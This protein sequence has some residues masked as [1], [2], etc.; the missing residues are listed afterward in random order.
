[1]KKITSFITFFL[2]LI[3]PLI[4]QNQ[5]EIGKPIITTFNCIDYGINLQVW[6]FV[7]DSRGIIYI[8]SAPGVFEFDGST[9][10]SIPTINNTHARS[11]A[12]DKNDRVYVGAS[13]DVGYLKPDKLGSL[14]FI[15]LL[16]EINKKYRTFSYV[17]TTHVINGNIY[18]QSFESIFR[19]TPVKK[20]SG[21]ETWKVKTWRP[22]VRFNYSFWLDNAYFVQQ[23]G[24]GLMKMVN[25]SLV[26]LPGGEQFANDRLQVMLPYNKDGKNLI[27]VGTFNKGLFLFDGKSFQP[28]ECEA[29]SFFIL[30]TLYKGK[31]LDDGSYVFVTLSG[32]MIIMD[33]DGNIKL[34]LNKRNGLSSNSVTGLF[35]DKGIIWISPEGSVSIVE[36]PSPLTIFDQSAGQTSSI[37]STVRYKGIFYISAT[38]GVF[39]LDKKTSTIK[40][41]TGFLTGNSQS[42]Q[43]KIVKDQLLTTHGTGFYRIIGTNASVIKPAAGLSFVPNF[44]H[45]SGLDSNRIFVGLI[46][47][48]STFYLD[49]KNEWVFEGKIDSVNDYIGSIIETSPGLLWASTDNNGILRLDFRNRPLHSPLIKRFSVEQGLPP[50]GSNAYKTSRNDYF[51]FWDGVYTYDSKKEKF[52]KNQVFSNAAN[53]DYSS[54]VMQEDKIGNIW[55][56]ANNKVTFYKLQKDGS[57]RPENTFTSRLARDAIG[58]IYPEDNG[59]VWFG[60][61]ST[62]YRLDLNNIKNY[63]EEFSTLVRK[64]T[65]G[66]DSVIFGGKA[67]IGTKVIP[68]VNF[69]TNSIAFDYSA[70]S[71]IDPA[72]TEYQS[73]LEG[74][75]EKW[76]LWKKDNNRNYTNLPTGDYTFKVRARNLYHTESKEAS[77][78]FDILTPWYRTWTAYLGYFLVLAFAVFSIDKYQ[79][80]RVTLKERQKA[81]MRETELRAQTAEAKSKALQAENERKKNIELLSEIGKEI[82][83][84]LDLDTI[85]YRLY[86]HVNQLADATIFGV[87]IYHPEKNEIEYRLA[88]EEGK[89]YP[90]YSRNTKDENQFPVWCILNRKPIFIND[91]TIE[92]KNYIKYYKELESV[93]EDGTVSKE[94]RSLI[95]LPLLSKERVLGVITIQSFKKEAY[96]NYH[97]NILQNLASYTAIAIDNADAYRQLNKTIEKLDTAIEDLKSTQE[98]LIVQQKLASLGQLTAGIAHEIKNPLNFVNN[99]AQLSNELVEELRDEFE[100]KKNGLDGEFVEVIQDLLKNI[101]QNVT[102][103]NEHGKRADSIVRSMLLHSRGKSGEKIPSDLN[104]I[105]EEDL[106]LAY[107]GM[108]AQNAEFNVSIEK[109][110]DENIG[111]INVVQQE[112]SRVFLNIIQNS[113]YETHR[114]KNHNKNNFSPVICIKTKDKGDSVE[115]RIYDNGDGI[116][117][118]IQDKLF[119]PFFTTK[120]AGQGTGLGLSL[121]YDIIVKQHTGEIK[122]ETKDGEFTEFIITLPKNGS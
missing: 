44:I 117:Y 81:R 59:V 105:L 4:A 27:L 109:S 119:D 32:G 33:H 115:I 107:H 70:T 113:F 48:L 61:V 53:L 47:G 22:K 39:Y 89:R 99:F 25:D 96:T 19:F 45:Q 122:F 118:E 82:T 13:G 49:K 78:S 63:D 30:N 65:I 97:L 102:K 17:W 74:F 46:D 10:R 110:F 75:D 35:V 116:P 85:F 38:N 101:E 92:Y 14:H 56:S 3:T 55:F 20:D 21:K 108:R 79:R 60:G 28:F 93:L 67:D 111:K 112:L 16:N 58:S 31:M 104:T 95:Y 83:A 36:Y 11:L 52:I 76:S 1:M 2:L 86:E 57:L 12:I 94:P 71:M 5:G 66:E 114:K 42:F 84:S 88:L 24:V 62:L 103:I 72:A 106:N 98:K 91:V 26:L 37:A 54:I 51:V 43:L 50:G 73:K 121:S 40:N 41:V 68:E 18:F 80:K 64:V 8:G 120:P 77:F 15:S 9:W 34:H 6:D 100:K 69:S 7:R 29:N 90:P 23:G 87:G